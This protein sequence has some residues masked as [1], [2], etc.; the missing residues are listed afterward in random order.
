MGH[1][2]NIIIE[3]TDEESNCIKRQS[4]HTK[5]V[6]AASSLLDLGYRH[7]EQIDILQS[8]QDALLSEQSP[9]VGKNFTEC[10]SCHSKVIKKGAVASDF[11]SVFTDHKI[12][13]RRQ[14]C[15]QCNWKNIPSIYSLFGTAVH[16]DL[17]KLQCESGAKSTYREASE[18]LNKLSNGLRRVNNHVRINQTCDKVGNY[19]ASNPVKANDDLAPVNAL[20]VQVD[21]GHVKSKEA[22]ERSFEVMT[23]VAFN[24]ENIAY[25][26]SYEKN[27]DVDPAVTYQ[28]GKLLSKHCAASSLADELSSIKSLT[29][30]A[31]KKEGLT[32]ATNIT[33][34][35]DGAQNCWQVV[36]HLRPHCQSILCILDWFHVGM[37]FKNLSLSSK[38]IAESAKNAKWHLWRGEVDKAIERLQDMGTLVEDKKEKKK[39]SSLISYFGNNRHAI[40]N[41]SERHEKG[42]C[43]S[44][45]LAE[46]NVESLINQ[47][48]KGKQHMRWTRKGL[49]PLMQIRATIASNDWDYNWEKVVCEAT[50][51]QAA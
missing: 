44:S 45:Q 16:P 19:I 47:R 29:L 24:P 51:K 17:S 26:I 35:C 14:Y 50:L 43:I 30:E 40:I 4:V 38:D 49:H 12:K 1:K 8:I 10:P 27:V 21:G 18:E 39:L 2:I 32:Q 22:D 34:L 6:I 48:C 23:S 13:I 25:S 5:N 31:A 41:Y 42:L 11:H 9:T 36:E 7:Q 15:S 28:R 3:I 20:C 46:S 37:K 33:A